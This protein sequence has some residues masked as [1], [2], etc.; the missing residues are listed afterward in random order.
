MK[1]EIL[2]MKALSASNPKETECLVTRSWVLW[3]LLG[4]S[5]R[6]E[7]VLFESGS[8]TKCDIFLPLSNSN[9]ISFPQ[10]HAVAA[11]IFLLIFFNRISFLQ[12][13]ILKGSSYT[14]CNI[15]LALL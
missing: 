7:H 14:R 1:A 10:G 9:I 4:L 8:S 15:H 6:V 11:Y 2:I 13:R 5:L 12:P 3:K